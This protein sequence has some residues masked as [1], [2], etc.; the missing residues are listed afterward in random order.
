MKTIVS[1]PRFLQERG[2]SNFSGGPEA[3]LPLIAW[4][5]GRLNTSQ[6]PFK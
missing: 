6:D 3:S 2:M 4:V 5:P 1:T